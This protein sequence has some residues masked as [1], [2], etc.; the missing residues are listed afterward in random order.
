M[1]PSQEPEEDLSP[2]SDASPEVEE[3]T[4]V[5]EAES[6]DSPPVEPEHV[7]I[8]GDA[9]PDALKVYD[10]RD[11][12]F[13][14]T[15]DDFERLPV[16]AKAAIAN[17]RRDYTRKTQALAAQRRALEESA[18]QTE[19]RS[20]ELAN[21]DLETQDLRAALLSS[22]DN[23][24]IRSK[25]EALQHEDKEAPPDPWS[26]E[27]RQYEIDKAVSNAMTGLLDSI[28]ASS[29]E[30]AEQVKALKQQR[31][32]EGRKAT[33]E[34]FKTANPD[35]DALKPDVIAFRKKTNYSI[36]FEESFDIIR[37][38]KA[39]EKGVTHDRVRQEA[40]AA[41]RRVVARPDSGTSR[42]SAQEPPKD[43]AGAELGRWF[44]EHPE[45][46]AAML[47]SIRRRA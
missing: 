10:D 32:V 44:Q 3:D 14:L 45:D 34:E 29:A 31:H 19:A 15:G 18:A 17:F 46:H 24:D 2:E 30:Q 6:G 1:F 41:S 27:G 47:A 11:Q 33:L 21:R 13:S 26:A 38:L 20:T 35:Y 12:D 39:K 4:P 25:I 42:K 22:I 16:E 5:I 36:P 9:A 37:A 40:R 8:F 28:S 43:L 23:P 7:D